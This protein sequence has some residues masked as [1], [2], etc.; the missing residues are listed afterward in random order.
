M[1]V[2]FVNP[3]LNAILNV[4]S[5][6][7]MIEAEAGKPYV[8]ANK[9]ALGDVSGMIGMAGDKVKGSFAITFTE[10]CILH[11]ASQMLGEEISTVDDTVRD[12]VGEI[13]NMVSGG[14]KRELSEKGYKFEMAIPSSITGK[15]HTITHKTTGAIIV[16]PFT[17]Q[18]IGDFFVEVCF[19]N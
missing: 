11:I 10:K 7:A 4:L 14:A 8:K 1:N 2:E 5:T 12:L 13:T 15:N 3:F 19:E 16:V 9:T 17:I 18:E 6:M